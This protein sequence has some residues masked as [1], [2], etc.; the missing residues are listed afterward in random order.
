MKAAKWILVSLSVLGS[1]LPQPVLAAGVPAKSQASIVDVALTD[2]G[3]LHGQVVDPQCASLGE[4]PVSVE[5]QGKRI[6]MLTTDENGYFA[7]GGLRSGVYQITAAQGQVTYRLWAPG[8]APPSA[9]KHVVVVRGQFGSGRL[10]DWFS[11]PWVV[12]AIVAAGVAVPVA[13][14]NSKRPSSP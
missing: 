5:S 1:C 2:D 6:V 4:V 13:I 14:A 9:E 8:T 11:S 3:V 12:G 7:V 10:C